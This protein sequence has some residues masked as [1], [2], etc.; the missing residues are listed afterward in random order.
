[1]HFNKHLIMVKYPIKIPHNQFDE[2]ELK[3]DVTNLPKNIPSLLNSS[4]S[5]D[6]NLKI[7]NLFKYTYNEEEYSTLHLPKRYL[8]IYGKMVGLVNGFVDANKKPE[9]VSLTYESALPL[10]CEYTH[11]HRFDDLK[12]VNEPKVV[13]LENAWYKCVAFF[14][15]N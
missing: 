5:N 1:M 7:R 12:L 3:Y 11:L 15:P 9:F 6:V 2:Y 13:F 4:C 14:F 8:E 10:N